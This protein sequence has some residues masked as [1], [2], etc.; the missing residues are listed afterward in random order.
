MSVSD[1][2]GRAAHQRRPMTAGPAGRHA[3]KSPGNGTPQRWPGQS[4]ADPATAPGH[5]RTSQPRN[6]LARA[7]ARPMLPDQRKPASMPPGR[8]QAGGYCAPDWQRTDGRGSLVV[9]S[10]AV[11]HRGCPACTRCMSATREEL[12]HLVDLLPE[13]ELRPAPETDPRACG[14]GSRPGRRD[15]P[16]FAS[17]EA[18]PPGS[19]NTWEPR[20]MTSPSRGPSSSKAS[21]A[22]V[23]GSLVMII[24]YP[25]RCLVQLS[26]HVVSRKAAGSGGVS[27]SY[28][29]FGCTRE[30]AAI[31]DL[32]GAA[33]NSSE[34]SA[35]CDRFERDWRR[36]GTRAIVAPPPGP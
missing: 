2:R 33:V 28:P 31:P 5:R 36:I 24:T 27:W 11:R 29:P 15:L 25:A 6:G 26:D 34:T 3:R 4:P 18:P 22:G 7:V 14:R 19:R 8:R 17:F 21:W 35:P 20:L 13:A 30:A 16:F 32:A 10:R 9:A 23:P 1:E 12:H